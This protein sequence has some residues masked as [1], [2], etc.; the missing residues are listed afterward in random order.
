M[1]SIS[2]VLANFSTLIFKPRVY[3]PSVLFLALAV[4]VGG[5]NFLQ[6]KKTEAQQAAFSSAKSRC[7]SWIDKEYNDI[8]RV[9]PA[10]VSG[11]WEKN[12]RL[13]VEVG[14]HEEAGSSTYYS[15]LCVVDPE[16]GRMFSPGAFSRNEWEEF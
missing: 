10:F 8:R 11:Y 14:W 7:Q 15:R 16:S 2:Y 5:W 4:F 12:G 1:F 9:A 3:I 6:N 13:V